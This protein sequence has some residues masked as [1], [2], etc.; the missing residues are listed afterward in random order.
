MKQSLPA[1]T[2]VSML[3]V[4]VMLPATAWIIRRNP[5]EAASLPSGAPIG[6]SINLNSATSR[7]LAALPGLGKASAQRIVEYR[8]KAGK[9]ERVEDL[10]KV[11]GI[12][13]RTLERMREYVA[14]GPLIHDGA[15]K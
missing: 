14:V 4:G 15:T 1:S 2:Y 7:E 5:M 12:G 10:L 9:F 11:K 8:E 13:S 6:F 3:L